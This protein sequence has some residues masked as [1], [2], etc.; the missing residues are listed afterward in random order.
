MAV[1]PVTAKLL[2]QL[3]AKA[4]TDEQARKRLLTAVLSLVIFLL[5]LIA[6]IVHLI[7]S[8]LSLFAQWITG[9]DLAMIEEF[10][11]DYGYHQEIGIYEQ[12]Y[13]EN[14]GQSYEGVVFSDGVTE[15]VY[16][17]Q[18]D[19]RWRN[20]SYGSDRIGSHGCGPSSMAIVV[21]SLSGETVDPPN[22]ARW[23]AENGYWCPGNGSYHSLIPAA[24]AAWGLS[25]EG[26]LSA[27]QIVDALTEGKLVVV[28]MGRGHFTSSGHFIVLRGVTAEGKILVADPGSV[29]RSGQEWDL[30]LIMEEARRGAGAGGPFWA[31]GE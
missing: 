18:G 26:N 25:C 31:L 20:S 19:E 10:Q 21:S 9:N 1:D 7:T 8:P 3:A 11:I 24:A 28:I 2:A 12:D 29:R 27:Q 4:A 6:F 13:R 17:N 14:I 5:L 15:V 22:M 16:Y 23:A 30:S